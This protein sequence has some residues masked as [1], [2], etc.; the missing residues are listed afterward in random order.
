MW[1]LIADVGGTHM[2]LAAVSSAGQITDRQSFASSGTAFPIRCA[3]FVRAQGAAPKAAVIAAAGVVSDGAVRLTN[4]PQSFGVRD[5]TVA[6]QTGNVTILNDFEA[7]A[8][9]LTT[10]APSDMQVLQDGSEHPYG[11][12][13]ILGPG[14]GLGVGVMLWREGQPH[15]IASEG[16]HICLGPQTAEELTWFERL[17]ALWPEVR[18]GPGAGVEAEAL[19]SG[20]GI[21]RLYEAVAL[22]QGSVLRA[23]TAQEVFA[24]AKQRAD[25]TAGITV[26]LFRR[27]LG[28][29]AGNLA[30]AFNASGGVFLTGGVLHH[31]PWVLDHSF[32]ESFNSGGRYSEMRA[33]MP[34][35]LYRNKD[36]GLS[37]ARNLAVRKMS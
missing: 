33:R 16:G 34:V 14:T 12:R 35:Y 1:T 18:I 21:P 36:M 19:L 15:V 23:C 27:Y 11:A 2:R 22:T 30:L 7:A 3:D 5:L 32:L 8:W 26:D 29:V 6:C 9:S 17:V 24:L 10:I 20:T 31:N 4:A 13:L 37:G 25:A 28:Q